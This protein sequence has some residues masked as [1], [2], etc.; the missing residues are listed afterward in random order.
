MLKKYPTIMIPMV[1]IPTKMPSSFGLTA[2]LN[3]MIEGRD[4]VVTPIMNDNTTPSCAP[5]ASNASA[6]GIVPKISA[7]MG[8]PMMVA[9]IT[10]KGLWLPRTATTQLSGIQL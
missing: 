7:Y 9:N 3:I 1:Q 6:T 10:P 5:F 2:F 8:M 4:N